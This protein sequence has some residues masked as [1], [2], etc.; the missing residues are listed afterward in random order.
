MSYAPGDEPLRVRNIGAE[1]AV[2]D[3]VIVSEDLE[4]V[5]Q[6]IER[7]S[8]F[9]RRASFEG[10]RAVSHTI[11]ANIDIVVLVHSL[12]SPP[13][14]RRLEREL[15]LAFDSGA[16]PAIVLT[17]SDL[18]D[19]ATAVASIDSLEQVAA[20]VPVLCASGVSGE[21]VDGLRA[22]VRDNE[23]MALL[24]ASGVG[25][26]TLINALVGSDALR[27]AEVREGD[28]RGRHT[29]TAVELVG[30][31]SPAGGAQH[32]WLIDTPGVRAVSLWS[33][34]RGIEWAFDDVFSLA[35]HCRFRNCK[36]DDEP[37]CAVRAAIAR[38]RLDGRRLDAMKR[39]V[40]EEHAL[41][42]EQRAWDKAQDRRGVRKIRPR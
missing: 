31:P 10:N 3:W 7:S 36:H 20:G 12:T 1:V 22:L 39:L 18:V 6:V 5:E 16:W 41:E 24:G 25:K 29:T 32:G 34:G 9:T 38:G 28:Q 26:S 14:Q 4:R 40:A 19:E 2:G 33:S 8:G 23:T 35:D 30:I 27:V 21:G 15:V 17:K 42:E 13:N 37:G 11:A